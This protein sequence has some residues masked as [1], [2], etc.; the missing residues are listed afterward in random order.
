MISIPATIR[1][2][3]RLV[4]QDGIVGCRVGN[5]MR[6]IVEGR[7]PPPQGDE[8]VASAAVKPLE[9]RRRLGLLLGKGFDGGRVVS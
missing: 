8:C 1:P 9:I 2:A 6:V 4:G 3:Q 7:L 5:D